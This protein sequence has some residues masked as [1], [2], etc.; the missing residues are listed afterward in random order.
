MMQGAQFL[1]VSVV[2][3]NFFLL[4]E[5]VYNVFS[6][7]LKLFTLSFQNGLYLRFSLCGSSEV[8]P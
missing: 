8:N 5:V 3:S 7:L 6:L 4:Q 1:N 2:L